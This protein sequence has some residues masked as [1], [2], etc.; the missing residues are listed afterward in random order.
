MCVRF[1]D[2]HWY[3]LVLIESVLLH[4]ASVLLLGG[5]KMKNESLEQTKVQVEIPDNNE[6]FIVDGFAEAYEKFLGDNPSKRPQQDSSGALLGGVGGVVMLFGISSTLFGFGTATGAKVA[7][8]IG[9]L[10]LF[11]GLKLLNDA[12]GVSPE[13]FLLD[14][15]DLVAQGGV[16]I[17]GA[18]SVKYL[19]DSKFLVKF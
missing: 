19:A 5:R 16:P 14:E 1:L 18:F 2:F 17:E 10:I 7:T 3:T 8:G 15:Y 11:F 13:Q 9:T 4:V 6:A 12:R